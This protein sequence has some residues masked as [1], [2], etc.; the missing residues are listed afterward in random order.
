MNFSIDD[1]TIYLTVHGSRAYGTN[2]DT[3]DTDFRGIAIPPKEY[4]LGYSFVFEQNEQHDPNDKVVFDIRK[5]FRLASDCN[6]NV[7]EILYTDPSNQIK[8]DKLGER[9]LENRELFLSRKA[10]YT[11]A[12]YAHS[13][14][15]RI[16]TH[17][18]WL[19]S[20]PKGKP[21][22]SDF[23]LPEEGNKI[24]SGS[25]MGAFD[26]LSSSGYSFGSDVMQVIQ[27][28]KQYASALHHWQQYEKWQK[29]RNKDRAA[30]E[31]QHGFD[32]KHALHLI[33]LLRMCV[34]ILSGKGVIVRRPDFEDLLAIRRGEWTYDKLIEEAESLDAEAARLYESSPLPKNP[35]VHKLDALCISLV[36]EWLSRK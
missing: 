25:T 30:L 31:A 17:R 27:K 34:E 4:F 6:P 18:S 33:R 24:V 1:H 26:E 14:L 7:V 13:Q 10:R 28:E 22:R 5:F 16:K 32:T 19:L 21:L 8:V 29:N 3:S 23:G 2:L 9:L 15:K 12:G 35:P 11:F 20:P 36:E